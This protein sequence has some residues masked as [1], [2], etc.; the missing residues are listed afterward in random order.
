MKRRLKTWRL[1]KQGL[2]VY[3]A[4]RFICSYLVMF[5]VIAALIWIFEP[6]IHTY[7]DSLWYCF[8]AA[9]TIGFGDVSAVSFLGR[10]LTVLLSLYSV[11]FIAVITAVITN[12]F[13]EIA[14]AR[15]NQSVMAFLNDLENLPDLSKEELEE[16][17]RRIKKWKGKE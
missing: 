15:A 7:R 1:L 17:S 3:G 6:N 11:I 8:A 13:M 12:F 2:K 4:D 5:A 10:A 9:T 14:K 16:L